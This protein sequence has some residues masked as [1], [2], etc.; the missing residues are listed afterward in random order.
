MGDACAVLAG[1][2]ATP[3]APPRV[4]V[5]LAARDQVRAVWRNEVG[6]LTFEAGM[7][8]GRRFIKWAPEDC[9]LDLRVEAER[10]TWL[11]P[12]DQVPRV[13]DVGVERG[14]P[15]PGSWL[16]TAPLPGESAVSADHRTHPGAAVRSIGEGLRHLHDNA[17]AARC[18]YSWS[19]SE[20]VRSARD[21]VQEG[22]TTPS[23]W[24]PEHRH[25]TITAALSILEEPPAPAGPPVVCHGDACAPNT[26]VDGDRWSGHVDLGAVGVADRWADLAIATWSTE[27]NY[28]PGWEATL[29]D[30]YGIE[31]DP[32]A[33]A[34][35]RLLWDLT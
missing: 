3:A 4:V 23:A 28:G 11:E 6:G 12:F 25:L 13:I 35:Y 34:Y 21:R 20:R 22:Q 2:P 17:P 19:Q 8:A 15:E 5:A 1:P 26:I 32:V 18:P 24:H 29:L 10:M 31:P 16:V 27:W 9:G 30:A 14:G 7:G 33:T